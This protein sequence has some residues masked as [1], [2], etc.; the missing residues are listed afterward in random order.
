MWKN[1]SH[2]LSPHFYHVTSTNHKLKSARVK[3]F[4]HHHFLFTANH[5]RKPTGLSPQQIQSHSQ[6]SAT[7]P[8][9]TNP[10][11]SAPQ[12]H[13]PPSPTRRTNDRHSPRMILRCFALVCRSFF[14]SCSFPVDFFTSTRFRL[15]NIAARA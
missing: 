10:D 4:L 12:P 3:R 11:T 2:L 8:P 6:P 13:S 14:A 5:L 7:V 9:K 15:P 1:T